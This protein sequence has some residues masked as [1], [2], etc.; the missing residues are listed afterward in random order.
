MTPAATT[1]EATPRITEPMAWLFASAAALSFLSIFVWHES[2][3]T[4]EGG[5][6][7][8][9]VGG[10]YAALAFAAMAISLRRHWPSLAGF[11]ALLF[12]CPLLYAAHNVLL[13]QGSTPSDGGVYPDWHHFS[14]S[15]LA[16]LLA[17]GLFQSFRLP[18][19]LGYLAV[20]SWYVLYFLHPAFPLREWIGQD[21]QP[22]YALWG[23]AL[24]AFG[25]VLS[26][27]RSPDRDWGYWLILWGAV[28]LNLSA[29]LMKTS[30]EWVRVLFLIMNFG[31]IGIGIT[32]GR[33]TVVAIGLVFSVVY[34][35][36]VLPRFITD[37]TLLPVY[38]IIASIGLGALTWVTWR[39]L[40][41]KGVQIRR[42]LPPAIRGWII[43][44]GLQ[45]PPVSREVAPTTDQPEPDRTARAVHLTH[46]LAWVWLVIAHASFV[47]IHR[48]ASIEFAEEAIVGLIVSLIAAAIAVRVI[49]GVLR[50]AWIAMAIVLC[51]LIIGYVSGDIDALLV[52]VG[53]F[54]TRGLDV[55]YFLY[56]ETDAYIP[57]IVMALVAAGITAALLIAFRL[58]FL[59]GAMAVC[60]WGIIHFAAFDYPLRDVFL[61]GQHPL[62]VVLGFL[63]IAA[64]LVIA[65][66]VSAQR[67]WGFWV[68]LFGCVLMQSA[69]IQMSTGTLEGRLLFTGINIALIAISGLVVRRAIT[70]VSVVGLAALAM[71]LVRDYTRNSDLFPMAAVGATVIVA[72][73]TAAAWWWWLPR[74]AT[75]SHRLPAW[76]QRWLVWRPVAA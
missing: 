68:V 74:A 16:V 49:F 21:Q 20:A 59:A 46:G 39:V 50:R 1:P 55:A 13:L 62:D 45:D 25:I 60:L 3:F 14:L 66:R 71:N 72:G 40:L 76:V 51:A 17:A 73:F 15:A 6:P 31:L 8:L 30:S 42:A 48:W 11:L 54:E 27:K 10:I 70:V 32:V 69:M 7:S 18:V 64:G 47:V 24:A 37:N 56:P 67:D 4:R 34:V 5:V 28:L 12:L 9:V 36:N 38:V 58:T 22:L 35:F 26:A 44:G 57:G 23:V 43:W 33:K 29:V 52:Q 19:L 63:G 2:R 61:H 75:L 53:A 41:P 65:T